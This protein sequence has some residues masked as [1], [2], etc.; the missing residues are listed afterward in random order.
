MVGGDIMK[1]AMCVRG[2]FQL[3]KL[4]R[5]SGCFDWEV[6]QTRMALKSE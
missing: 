6:G 3:K 1:G 2:M 5:I 4:S